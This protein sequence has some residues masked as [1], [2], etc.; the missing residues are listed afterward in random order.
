MRVGQNPAKSEKTVPKP[1]NITVCT[2][3]YIPFL[4]G[5]YEQ[6]LD[7]LKESLN[8]LWANTKVP[9]DLLVF[10]NNSCQEV[11]EFLLEK[12]TQGKIQFLNLS[13]KNIG[14]GGAWNYIFGA[15]PGEIVAYSDSDIYYY[16]R[17]LENSIKLMDVYPRVGMVTGRPI[18]SSAEYFTS[19]IDWAE[20]EENIEF[21]KSPGIIPWEIFEQHTKS[22]G[23]SESAAR[24]EHKTGTIYHTRYKNLNAI[25][26]AGHFQFV[27]KRNLLIQTGPYNWDKPLGPDRE[28]D[29]WFND[30]GYLRLCL[31][32]PLVRHIGNRLDGKVKNESNSTNSLK[33]KIINNR[34]IRGVLL[35][36][37]NHI[38]KLYFED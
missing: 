34:I 11:K 18:Y 5:Y 33:K 28:L 24:N 32:T 20:N 36:L 3:I 30:N 27:S 22:L 16:P 2:I 37:Y 14:K 6:S 12:Q 25:M 1:K 17:W 23:T 19:T 31:D 26:G 10:D 21:K 29:V 4:S 13:D 15:A 8:S 7:V 38:F 9:F 35:R